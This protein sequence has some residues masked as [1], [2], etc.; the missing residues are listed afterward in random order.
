MSDKVV[1]DRVEE[2]HPAPFDSRAA[3]DRYGAQHGDTALALIGN[4]RVNLTEEDVR[5]CSLLG[6]F[7]CS[8][9]VE[10]A[11]SQQNR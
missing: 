1:I 4:K 8:L 9:F 3:K 5:D 2:A 10:Q 6:L 11:Y 7:G